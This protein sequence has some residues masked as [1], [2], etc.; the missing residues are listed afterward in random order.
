MK[1]T[2]LNTKTI[3][4]HVV[5][6]CVT[7]VT[8]YPIVQIVG[9]SLRPSDR[10][11]STSLSIIPE[12]ATAQAYHDVLFEKD[13]L[14]WL[15]NSTIVA[16]AVTLIGVFLAA[17]SGYAFSRFRFAIRK[18]GLYSFLIAQM[19]PATMLLLPLYVLMKGLHLLNS[20]G[21]LAIAYVAT[22]LPFCVWTMKGYY[23]TIPR[24]LEEAAMM[25]GA[26]Y[27]RA[28]R[29]VVLPLATPA[30]AITAIFS[31]MAAWSEFMVARVIISTKSLHTL[32]LGLES[33]SSTF[34]TEWANYAAGSV[35]VSL[36]VVFL[37]LF[38]NR[39]LVSGLTLGSVKQ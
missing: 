29:T 2:R 37:F 20:L 36:P 23:D 21:G 8:I 30:L 14:L 33:L 35:L 5:I 34:Q 26:S 13:F 1:R 39:F 12:D 4:A 24:E 6:I 7:L 17:T 32:P 9:I 38:L 28:F 3:I 15:R 19:F 11:Y 18:S 31:F 25:D 27:W 10:L 16:G 22:A